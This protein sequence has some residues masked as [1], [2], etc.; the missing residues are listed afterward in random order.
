MKKLK[1][2]YFPISTQPLEIPIL[3][4]WSAYFVEINFIGNNI[5]S[6]R[7]TAEQNKPQIIKYA[8]NNG[9]VHTLFFNLIIRIVKGI[10]QIQF[11]QLKKKNAQDGT[12]TQKF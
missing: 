3:T 7:L 9:D 5:W 8:L 6:V 10:I 12:G 2:I 4:T 1:L 11:F